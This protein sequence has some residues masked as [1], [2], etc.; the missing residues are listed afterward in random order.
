VTCLGTSSPRSGTGAKVRARAVIRG[1]EMSQ[2]RLIN[3]GGSSW[4]GQSP[5]AH[6][7]LRDAMNVV[8]LRIE[9]SS[10]IVQELQNVP[11][12]Q[13][14]TVTAPLKLRM[15]QPG[16]LQVECWQGMVCRVDISPDLTDWAPLST[17]TNLT[18]HLQWQD[19]EAP[20]TATRYY[21]AVLQQHP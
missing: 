1:Q 21:R 14:L 5:V 20:S 16:E 15:P 8:T 3:S 10:G 17:M 9:W 18:G 19:P 7:G 4:G 13:H 6:F 2:L 12:N 11:A